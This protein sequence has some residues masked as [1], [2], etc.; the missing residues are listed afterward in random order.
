MWHGDPTV[1]RMRAKLPQVKA[2][3]LQMLYT[4]L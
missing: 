3:F 4:A 1:Q 2:P